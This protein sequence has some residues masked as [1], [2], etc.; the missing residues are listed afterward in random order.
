MQNEN[1]FIYITF[2]KTQVQLDQGPRDKPGYPKSQK[3]K[4]GKILEDNCTED[5]F[6][7]TNSS[8]CKIKN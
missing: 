2:S 5:N 4:V 7:N 6:L 1:R 3:E 8:G